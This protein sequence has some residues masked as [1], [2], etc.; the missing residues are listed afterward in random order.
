VNKKAMIALAAVTLLAV[1]GFGIYQSGASA[2]D[3]ELS[4]K[5]IQELV[6][7]QY[8][9]TIVEIELEKDA[10]SASYHVKTES[11]GNKYHITLDGN[12]GE[13]VNIE[14]IGKIDTAQ[15]DASNDGS[16]QTD[17]KETSQ[18]D[19]QS[20]AKKEA[21]NNNDSKQN[22]EQSSTNNAMISKERAKE[23]ALDQFSGTVKEIELDE[24][25]GK[26]VYEIE[27]ENNNGEATMEID[28]YTGE[29]VYIQSEME[30]DE[31]ADED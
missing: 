18:K 29:V 27:I 26:H 2:S 30:D 10:N 11:N 4:Q 28:A 17:D 16:S 9:G 22:Q 14:T 12:S 6:Q 1:L 3:P 24:D 19:K 20:E 25:D 15:K 13:V 31:E 7:K 21:N 5:E 23:I 8:P